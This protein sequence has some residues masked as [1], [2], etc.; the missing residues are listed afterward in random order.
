MN[1]EEKQ[2]RGMGILGVSAAQ[3]VGVRQ[4]WRI[5]LGSQGDGHS[6]AIFNLFPE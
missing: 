5:L 6:M 2:S 1:G 4:L 3:T